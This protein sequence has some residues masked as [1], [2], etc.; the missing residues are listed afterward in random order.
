[1]TFLIYAL[2]N[3]CLADWEDPADRYKDAYKHYLSAQCPFSS[4]EIKHF[5][6]LI[7]ERQRIKNHWML[8]HRGVEGAQ[9]MYSWRQ[10][11]PERDQY[12][13][14]MI[15]ED[16]NYLGSRGKKLFVQ[17]QD[18]T[19]SDEYVAVPKYIQSEGFDGGVV[20]QREDNG[21]T[22]GW[23]AKRWSSA[24]QERLE[25]LLIAMGRQFD[26]RIEGINLQE[27]AI[28]VSADQDPSFTNERYAES[29]RENMRALKDAFPTS[30]TMQYANFMPG[31][32]L[33]WED[34]GYL[35]SL[36]R[37]GQE[38]GVGLGGPDLMV[39]RKGQL[40]HTIAMMHE[41]DY[42]VPLG[43]AI[44]DGN[45]IGVTGADGNVA[46]SVKQQRDNLVPML[47]EF[48]RDFMKVDYMF[49]VDQ[50]PY[51]TKDVLPCIPQ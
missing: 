45:Y 42:T 13:F 16:L 10:L 6:Y 18:A 2:A 22:A 30:T 44:Q 28:G 21:R 26:G 35:A 38:I 1:M 32:W 41:Y 40:N 20:Q 3:D 49:W 15:E 33:P 11:E 12:D 36:Y 17:L 43:V 34:H 25:R 4:G 8:K 7:R 5:V 51:I 24:V 50:E 27:S 9:I 37:Y 19:F 48:A 47:Y 29:L 23:V 14:S 31:E 39:R 46:D